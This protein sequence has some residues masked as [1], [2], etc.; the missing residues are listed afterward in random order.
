M[1]ERVPLWFGAAD[2]DTLLDRFSNDKI[3]AFF[4]RPVGWGIL[5]AILLVAIV[6]KQRILFVAIAG[7]LAVSFLTRYTLT[8]HE[9]GPSKTLFLFAGG[10]VAIGAFVIY[11]LFIRED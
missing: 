9:A 3:I 4:T 2:W 10:V 11:F 8:G 6:L 5:G 1:L 7:A